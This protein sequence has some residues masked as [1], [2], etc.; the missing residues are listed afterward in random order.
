MHYR[1]RLASRV[2]GWRRRRLKPPATGD[3]SMPLRLTP[4]YVVR[5]RREPDKFRPLWT[6]KVGLVDANKHSLSTLRFFSQHFCSPSTSP[7][8]ENARICS[9][10]A[11]RWGGAMLDRDTLRW[12][13]TLRLTGRLRLKRV[14]SS[15][16]NLLVEKRLARIAGT[17]LVI[18]TAGLN[19]LP[20][21]TQQR[22][23][24]YIYLN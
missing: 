3:R 17:N 14:P 13:N 21:H 5:E 9:P 12:L 8:A 2:I 18:T 22:M 4:E 23:T 20:R 15:V 16:T 6:E 19:G 7:L 24:S 1:A 11:N 10:H